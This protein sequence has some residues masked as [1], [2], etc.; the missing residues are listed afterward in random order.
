MSFKVSFDPYLLADIEQ[1]LRLRWVNRDATESAIRFIEKAGPDQAGEGVL[2][3][4][5]G[6]GKTYIA[7][8]LVDYLIEQGCRNIMIVTPNRVVQKKTV[9]NF[10]PGRSKHIGGRLTN[11]GVITPDNLAY[12]F[13]INDRE[14]KLFIF[15]I[16]QLLGE[17]DDD[18]TRAIREA[19]EVIGQAVYEYLAEQK[20]LV[21]I[22][23]EHHLYSK[24]AEKFSKA[25]EDMR[26]KAVIGLTATPAKGLN[27]IFE[28]TI[29]QAIGQEFVKRPVICYRAEGVPEGREDIQLADACA[30]LRRKE[31]AY[32]VY[33]ES[34][35]D[36]PHVNPMLLVVC[37][38][39]DDAK[40]VADQLARAGYIGDRDQV[41][42]ITKD[43]TDKDTEK[44]EAVAEPTS[45]IRAIVSV[46]KLGVGWDVPN[47][48]VILG[49]RKLASETLTAQI[50]GRGLRLPYGKI[51]GVAEV[52]QV[53]LVAHESYRRL[54]ADRNVLVQRAMENPLEISAA[55]PPVD[56]AGIPQPGIPAPGHPG[57]PSTPR[58]A[59]ATPPIASKEITDESTAANEPKY[60][61]FGP[62]YGYKTFPSRDVQFNP[63]R[64]TYNLATLPIESAREAGRK[65]R[66]EVTSAIQRTELTVDRDGVEVRTRVAE[67]A[68]LV[69]GANSLADVRAHIVSSVL[70]LS[71]VL[72]KDKKTQNLLS[73]RV[74]AYLDGSQ[75]REDEPWGDKRLSTAATVMRTLVEG[76]A[77]ASRHQVVEYV[78][79]DVMVPVPDSYTLPEPVLDQNDAPFEIRTFYKGWNKSLIEV[80]SFDSR[81]PELLLARLFHRSQDVEWWV[82]LEPR[83]PNGA[84][85]KYRDGAGTYYP[86]F[87]VHLRSGETWV[88]EGK[89]A[90]EKEDPAVVDKK[91]AATEWLAEVTAEG[92]L[93]VWRYMLVVEKQVNDSM[94]WS[95]LVSIADTPGY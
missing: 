17:E 56:P 33:E 77:K 22:S 37:E 7:A 18:G 57:V 28:F 80:V 39:V 25:I 83:V 44:L 72:T 90:H 46:N 61:T 34:R 95:E 27:I 10:T 29:G 60:A 81:D 36:T 73:A 76:H 51:T 91:T 89:A 40:D 65:S 1:G 11:P 62:R 4:A 47:V 58:P 85:I 35:S 78:R 64:T 68:E 79:R 30:L 88:I 75:A 67:Q 31:T 2:S 14:P 63:V 55:Q 20:D 59:V 12:A 48:A 19:N 86:D 41:L 24:S 45:P 50:L 93:G 92:D 49:F 9:D 82:K 5:T 21:V 94:T 42:L 43:S 38:K 87:L 13:D 52:D 66:E 74:D 8:A 32:R 84:F 3:L 23:D 15:N 53:D 54:L 16:H 6:A 26:A 71:T 70:Q 69:E